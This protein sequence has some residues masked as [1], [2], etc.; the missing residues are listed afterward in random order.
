MENK[1]IVGDYL[2]RLDFINTMY[3]DRTFY[4]LGI[5]LMFGIGNLFDSIVSLIAYLYLI[6]K[7]NLNILKYDKFWFINLI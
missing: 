1:Q 3:F 2:N 4:W 7:N 5:A 6:K